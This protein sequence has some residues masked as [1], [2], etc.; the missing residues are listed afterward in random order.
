MRVLLISEPSGSL[1]DALLKS[2]VSAL[3]CVTQN[4]VHL[5]T[6]AGT[7]SG[8][9]IALPGLIDI[10]IPEIKAQLLKAYP[11]IDR[12]V[13]RKQSISS[14][15]ELMLEYTTALIQIIG[16]HPPRFAVLETGAPHHLFSYCLDVALKCLEI[17]VYYLYGNAFDGRC[18]VVKGNEKTACI[19]VS[20]YSARAVI[21][22]Y[23]DQVQRNATYIPE[24]SSKSLAPFLHNWRPYAVYLYLKQVAAKHYGRLKSVP[25]DSFSSTISLRLPYVGLIELIKILNEHR[26]YRRLMDSSVVFQASRIQADDVVY[27]GHMLPEATSFPECPDYPG[28]IDILLDL[29]NRF[30]KSRIFYREHP[31]IAIYSEFGHIHLQGLHKNPNF[32]W[33]MHR[34]EIE[35]I[36]PS[37]HISKIRE[38]GCIF[39]TKTGRVAVENSVLGIPTLIYG[40]PFYG[41]Q[42]PL[43]LNIADLENGMTPQRI[44][45]QAST[46]KNPS[47]AVGSYLKVRFSGSIHNPGIG[48]GNSLD[49]RPAFEAEIIRLILSLLNSQANTCDPSPIINAKEEVND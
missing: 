15:L 17:P 11:L 48:L 14:T 27:V 47:Q 19:K 36:P 22:D 7:S 26:K 28:E 5:R 31:A 4:D 30:P 12:W 21:D 44:K 39:A 29:K 10:D 20:D 40:F 35:V 25:S 49:V 16:N 46:C 6:A 2:G 23:I 38:R 42:L 37:I 9:A 8:S 32:Y 45:S 13:G 24:D 18:L 33:Q 3:V 43:T 1:A 41:R 34:L